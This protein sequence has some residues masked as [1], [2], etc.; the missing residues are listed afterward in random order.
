MKPV[1]LVVNV[2]AAP[3]LVVFQQH[4][5]R[6]DTTIRHAIVREHEIGQVLRNIRD[7]SDAVRYKS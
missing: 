5:D 3:H 1:T 2:G 4:D 7:W 6:G